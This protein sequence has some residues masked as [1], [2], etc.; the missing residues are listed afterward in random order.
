MSHGKHFTL[1][2][3]K[4]APNAWR[5]P[6]ILEELGLSYE[7]VFLDFTK[8]EHKAPEY[9]KYNPNGRVPAIVDHKNDD[10][11]LWESDA[12][13]TYLVDFYDPE[14]TIS[15]TGIDKYFQLQW[16]FFQAS[17]QGPPFGNAAWY[18]IFSPEKP[19]AVLARFRAEVKRVLAVL[20]SVLANQEWLVGGKVTVADLSFIPWN[21]FVIPDAVEPDFDFEKEFPATAAWHKKLFERPTVQKVYALRAELIAS[22]NK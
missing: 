3:H 6:I 18:A 21:N 15:V 13:I 12:I 1:F 16:L 8:G 5:V 10:L 9:T 22:M 20:E 2:G 7:L 11:V 19:P 4:K 14:H 17:G